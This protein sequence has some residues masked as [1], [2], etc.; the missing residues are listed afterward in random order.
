MNDLFPH[1]C[2]ALWKRLGFQEQGQNKEL[3]QIAKH[4]N[5]LHSSADPVSQPQALGSLWIGLKVPQSLKP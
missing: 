4:Q 3:R 1:Y 5:S 2:G